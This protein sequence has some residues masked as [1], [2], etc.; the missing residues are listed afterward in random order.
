[1][2]LS[3]LP[4]GVSAAEPVADAVA[5]T[6]RIDLFNGRDFSGWTF[7]MRDNAEPLKTWTV[8]NGVLHCSGQPNGYARTTQ[9]YRDYKLTVEWRFVK[10]AP[11]ADNTG[12]F[13]HVQPPD[14][15]WPK[16]IECQGQDRHQGDLILVNGA[17]FNGQPPAATFRIIGSKEASNE[18]PAGEWNTYEIVCAGDALKVYVNGKLMNSATGCNVS[19][20]AIA[21]QSEGGEFEVRKV[22]LEPIH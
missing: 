14:R 6:A 11:Q 1:M 12:V 4:S 16:C 20:G 7:C 2:L 8:T 17:G 18:K 13:V 10:V 15:V 22:Y 21:L 9:A 5:P 19:S 3:L